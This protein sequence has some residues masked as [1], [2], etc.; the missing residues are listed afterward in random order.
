[1]TFKANNTIYPHRYVKDLVILT[2]V[3]R[4][5]LIWNSMRLESTFNI[6]NIK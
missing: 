2:T 5:M 3:N 6:D 4:E 1:M